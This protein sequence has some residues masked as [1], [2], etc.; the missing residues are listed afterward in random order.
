V[1]DNRWGGVSVPR[2][3]AAG[4]VGLLAAVVGG[5]TSAADE[6]S[7][8]L[9]Q[10][11]ADPSLSWPNPLADTG[12]D[13][14]STYYRFRRADGESLLPIATAE[15]PLAVYVGGDSLSGGPA[16]GF[17]ELI[18]DDPAYRLTKGVRLSTGVITEWYFDWVAH[19]RDA[20]SAGGYDVIVL[21]MGGNDA[22]RFRSHADAVASAEWR[23]RYQARVAEMLAA[24]D[25]P[26]RLV[27][28]LGMPAVSLST[29]DGLPEVVNPLSAAA[30]EAGRRS[31]YVDAS[32][33]V[34]PD[35]VF[36]QLIIDADGRELEV[37]EGDGIHYTRVGG[38]LIGLEL[39][40][41]IAQHS[42]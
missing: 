35:G 3:A 42:G 36:T 11:W 26:A 31:T 1:S 16:F 10:G 9:L 15:R 38:R 40:D 14:E 23:A 8:E 19:L 39:L 32:A 30:A 12:L 18:E 41:V 29:L 13:P 28:W 33:I 37:R 6:M 2:W 22:Q 7:P 17:K 25:S 4:L 21:S 20:V 27:I 5:S 24:V 34:A